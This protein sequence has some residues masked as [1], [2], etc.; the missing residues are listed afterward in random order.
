MTF[1][2]PYK[3]SLRMGVKLHFPLLFKTNSSTFSRH[4]TPTI[5][6]YLRFY[7]D[8]YSPK[9]Q[10]VKSDSISKI[11]NPKY[12]ISRP[13]ET[14]LNKDK[15]TFMSSYYRL[16][17]TDIES[18]LTRKGI[19]FRSTPSS[20][21]VKVCNFCHPIKGKEDNMWKLYIYKDSGR[22]ICYRCSSK[23]S[24]FDFKAR[25]G[26]L[27]YPSPINTSSNSFKESHSEEIQHNSQKI[28][29]KTFLQTLKDLEDSEEA[30]E[31]LTKKRGLSMEVIRKYK[32]GVKKYSFIEGDKWVE[33]DCL[34]FPWFS[35][36]PTY[37]STSKKED[38]TATKNNEIHVEDFESENELLDEVPSDKCHLVRLKARSLTSKKNQRLDPKGPHW[39]F[40]GWNTI[41]DDA[42]HI[43][44][45]EGEFDAMAVHQK[46][47]EPTISLP[48]GA[49]SLPIQLLPLLERFQ[50][51]YLWLDND[52]PGHQSAEKFSMKLGIERCQ[53]L[54]T[55]SLDQINASQIKDAN[56][57]LLA[58]VDFSK[59]FES[60]KVLRHEE[61]LTFED[62]KNEIFN[63]LSNPTAY[64]GVPCRVLPALNS[65]LKGHRK[66][67]LTIVTG[68]TGVGKTSFLS[69]FSLDFCEQGV[70]TLWG[71]FEIPNIKLAKKMLSQFSRKNLDNISRVEFEEISQT[72]GS[73]PLYFLKFY[74]G[75]K[76]EKIIDAMEYAVYVYDVEHI[77]LDNLQFI[78][79]GQTS[80][81]FDRF[82]L[83]DKAFEKFRRF[84]TKYNVHVSLVVHPRK[85]DEDSQLSTASVFGSAKVTQEADNI[86]ILQR[87]LQYKYLEVTKNRFDGDLGKV[88][89][90]YH[91]SSNRFTQLTPQQVKTFNEINERKEPPKRK[92]KKVKSVDDSVPT[93]DT[94][95]FE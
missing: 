64:S 57:A 2:L 22:W 32:V 87:G 79:S 24:W 93:T 19:E 8:S 36:S 5:S 66:G 95:V 86:I 52:A 68:P 55:D 40:F 7:S 63:E 69:Q 73:L 45:T 16:D 38:N 48:N 15:E 67:E 84:A 53:I 23:G 75:T 76:V 92:S 82:D 41:P 71:S 4:L 25:Q 54:S 43:V 29:H 88:A 3:S 77:I 50:K 61:I 58:G 13:R 17:S 42:K 51:I 1:L 65:I 78:L 85:E 18:Y 33:H 30:I 20:F 37:S 11:Q 21:I 34:T 62:M 26:D 60:A 10:Y 83:Q 35:S 46:T 80:N 14:N 70:N 6:S 89:V 12:T 59:I 81:Q 47:G 49:S 28:S 44:I 74:G 94:F 90:D 72:F 9:V 56:D 31:Y 91:K 27:M 39:G